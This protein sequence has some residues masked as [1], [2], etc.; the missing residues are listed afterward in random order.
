MN[1]SEKA[2]PTDRAVRIARGCLVPR[3]EGLIRVL[4][5]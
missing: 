5:D 1:D 4:K 3:N 2:T